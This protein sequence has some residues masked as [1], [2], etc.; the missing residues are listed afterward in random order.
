MPVRS[1]GF[2]LKEHG[3][4]NPDMMVRRTDVWGIM[5][6]ASRTPSETY[7]IPCRK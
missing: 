1:Y 7:I 2:L 5:I 3:P 4:Q 6:N